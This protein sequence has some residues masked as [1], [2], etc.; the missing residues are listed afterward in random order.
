M[1]RT[2]TF[3]GSVKVVLLTRTITL[4][5]TMQNLRQDL[6]ELHM[7]VVSTIG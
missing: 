2:N 4:M 6:I 7:L 5:K 3:T 1:I